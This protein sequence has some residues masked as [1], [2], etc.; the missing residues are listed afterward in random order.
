MKALKVVSII[1]MTLGFLLILYRPIARI[2]HWPEMTSGL[3][4]G[5][6]AL[7]IGAIIIIVVGLKKNNVW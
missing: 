4:V 3:Y 5:L 7:I 6:I 1:L 2:Q